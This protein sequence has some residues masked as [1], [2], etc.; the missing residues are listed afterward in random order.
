ME[1]SGHR[2]ERGKKHT[3]ISK[4]EY[5]YLLSCWFYYCAVINGKEFILTTNFE[6]WA[7]FDESKVNL[8]CRFCTPILNSPH[9]IENCNGLSTLF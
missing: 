8:E 2:I 4:H 5:K 6:T 9:I 7:V 1:Y 3:T